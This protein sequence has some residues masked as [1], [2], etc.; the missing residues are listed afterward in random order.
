LDKECI[1][2]HRKGK[3]LSFLGIC[4]FAIFL[5]ECRLFKVTK[6]AEGLKQPRTAAAAPECRAL[7]LKKEMGNDGWKAPAG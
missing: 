7:C 6:N 4:I 2:T 3:A 1:L 5:L